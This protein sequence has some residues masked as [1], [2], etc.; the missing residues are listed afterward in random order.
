[1]LDFYTHIYIYVSLMAIH[2]ILT[3]ELSAKIKKDRIKECLK[4]FKHRHLRY[5]VGTDM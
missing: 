3:H 5:E 4:K 2:I 1:M